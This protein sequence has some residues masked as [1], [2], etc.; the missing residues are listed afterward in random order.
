MK[1]NKMLAGL[2]AA[3]H[4]CH[5]FSLEAP[6]GKVAVPPSIAGAW[7]IANQDPVRLTTRKLMAS[8][9][10]PEPRHFTLNFSEKI[11]EQLTSIL[12]AQQ[13]DAVVAYEFMAG[14]YVDRLPL[15]APTAR[16]LDGCEPFAFNW[17]GGGV[18]GKGRTVKFHQF[19]RRLIERFDLYITASKAEL[20]WIE[21]SLRPR[22]GRGVCIVNGADPD[23]QPGAA[24]DP[25]RIVYTGSLMYS[26]N[27]EAVEYFLRAVWP[28]V[29]EVIPQ[30]RFAVTG[31]VPKADFVQSVREAPNTN[32]TG[33]L[34]DY[35]GFVRSSAALVAPI[36]SGGGSRVKVPEALALG[37]PVIASAKAVEGLDLKPG[38]EFIL[39]SEPQEYADAVVSVLTDGAFRRRLSDSGREA[40]KRYSWTA[41]QTQFVE[42][43]E[44]AMGQPGDSLRS[45]SAHQTSR[46]R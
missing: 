18:R 10:A 41:A 30:A 43:V 22:H 34:D 5:L 14:Y 11:A 1:T 33:L 46:A 38:R 3:G 9:L 25:L 31:E 6:S 44:T 12:E 7:T 19:I 26:A 39:A 42:A 32:L 16:I 21:R 27:R 29:L 35:R 13:F 8:W 15:P 45:D 4:D 36:S 24:Y 37:C 28:L 20:D 40:A 2:V 23:E 17:P